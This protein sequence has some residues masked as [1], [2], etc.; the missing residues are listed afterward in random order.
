MN[1]FRTGVTT[2]LIAAA[3]IFGSSAAASAEEEV[4]PADILTVEETQAPV[5]PVEEEPVYT[6]P[7]PETKQLR[8]TLPDGATWPQTVFNAELIPCGTTVR[9]QVDT[10]PYT[11]EEDKART[12]A[13]DDDGFLTEGEDYGWA[14]S[15]FFEDYTAPACVVIPPAPEPLVE[16][17]ESS[18]LNCEADL[19]TTVTEGR[20]TGEPIYVEDTNS[21]INGEWTSWTQIESTGREATDVECPV[22]VPPVVE[23]PVV[24]PP[25]PVVEKPV[26]KPIVKTAAVADFE[27]AETG[28]DFDPMLA[29]WI[30][31]GLIA[32]G[33]VFYLAQ[34]SRRETR[35][36][37]E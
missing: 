31:L 1:R 12:D 9:V 2:T 34:L 37:A 29:V 3:M 26:I 15:W 4:P 28:S 30:S 32:T 8:W 17:R 21:W 24:T 27:L 19:V 6:A 10:Y 7:T 36:R 25:E 33:G 14:Q 23:P 11:T 18:S 16:T 22:V 5:A 13:L 20:T 35:N